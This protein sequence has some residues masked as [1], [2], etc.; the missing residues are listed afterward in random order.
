MVDMKVLD[1][2]LLIL[3]IFSRR[4][5]S[6]EGRI[7]VELA[8][9][10]YILPRLMGKGI[11]M[12]RLMGGIGGRGPGETKLEVDRR[13]VRLRIALLEKDLEKVRKRRTERRKLRKKTGHPL[14]SIIGYT[15]AGKSTLHNR[16]TGTASPAE[17][18]L[19]ATLDPTTR[20]CLIEPGTEILIS[21]TVGFIKNMPKDLRVAFRATLEELGDAGLFLHVVDITSSYL[22]EEIQVVEEL[23]A[24]MD[25]LETP[26]ILVFNKIDLEGVKVPETVNQQIYISAATGEGIRQL[27]D[28]I[29]KKLKASPLSH[30]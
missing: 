8:Q 25:I 26:R 18:R 14:V 19:F 22:D 9:L 7:Q 16:L 20:K 23:L 4:A 28:K 30:N 29:I 3:D 24:D 11:A 6:K 15:N 5:K 13:K 12:S 21:D 27:K 10:K 2:T 1:R 17:D